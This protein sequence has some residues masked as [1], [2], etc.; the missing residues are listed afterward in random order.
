MPSERLTWVCVP[1]LA[2][3]QGSHLLSLGPP[4][5]GCGHLTYSLALPAG[6]A[7]LC[8]AQLQ[9]L[10]ENWRGTSSLVARAAELSQHPGG[11]A[12]AAPP[13]LS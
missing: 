1:G 6:R 4:W 2:D 8:L 11:K 10:A 3:S 12:R 9:A 5:R 13:T 7:A